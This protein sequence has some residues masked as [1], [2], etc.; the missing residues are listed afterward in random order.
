MEEKDIVNSLTLRRKHRAFQR[1][2]L[3]RNKK[4]FLLVVV[5]SVKNF[6]L[7]LLFSM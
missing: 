1:E 4:A 3:A 2:N 6:C 5:L 7:V